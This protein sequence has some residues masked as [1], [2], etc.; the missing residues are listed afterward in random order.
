ML[1]QFS[2]KMAQERC[3][4]TRLRRAKT[5]AKAQHPDFKKAHP[6]EARE[7]S[8]GNYTKLQTRVKKEFE[9]E[10]IRVQQRRDKL[11]RKQ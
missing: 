6:D 9:D 5:Q 1:Q 4:N 2:W 3:L 10:M 8:Q 11:V 7:A